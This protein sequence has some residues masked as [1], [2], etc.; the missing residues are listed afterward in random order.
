MRL[1]QPVPAFRDPTADAAE[2][3]NP[4]VQVAHWRAGQLLLA[5]AAAITDRT[6][7]DLAVS[8]ATAQV[9]DAYTAVWHL[10][11]G[12]AAALVEERDSAVALMEALGNLHHVA[13]CPRQLEDALAAHLTARIAT[14][15]LLRDLLIRLFACDGCAAAAGEVCFSS[16]MP[17]ER[18]DSHQPESEFLPAT[19]YLVVPPELAGAGTVFAKD[20]DARAFVDAAGVSAAVVTRRLVFPDLAPSAIAAAGPDLTPHTTD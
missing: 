2:P 17:S 13:E 19:V 10:D 3:G 8:R 7:R 1:G 16:C 12:L 4:V 14:R 15:D 11:T 18:N 9:R 20:C 5:A 6:T